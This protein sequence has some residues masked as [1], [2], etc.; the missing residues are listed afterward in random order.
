MNN[1]AYSDDGNICIEKPVKITDLESLIFTCLSLGT[2]VSGILV[3]FTS[4]A[5]GI[6]L[7]LLGGIV[8]FEV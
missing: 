4:F 5:I 1:P 6:S 3:C 7:I 8:F 2:I